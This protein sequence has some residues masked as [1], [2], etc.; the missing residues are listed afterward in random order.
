MV[1]FRNLIVLTDLQV[2]NSD[3]K[4]SVFSCQCYLYRISPEFMIG[5]PDSVRTFGLEG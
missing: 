2:S 5:I 1:I 4:K 3:C